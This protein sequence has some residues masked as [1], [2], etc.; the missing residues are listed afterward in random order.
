VKK[1]NQGSGLRKTATPHLKPPQM[2]VSNRT[3]VNIGM[4]LLVFSFGELWRFSSRDSVNYWLEKGFNFPIEGWWYWKIL[5]ENLG[6]VI[7]SIVLVRLSKM[8]K[9]LELV[10]IMH[11]IYRIF[12][13]GSFLYNFNRN[14]G[15]YM[16]AYASS[17]I[18]TAIVY[19]YMHLRQRRAKHH[20]KSDV[21]II[22]KPHNLLV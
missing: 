3:Y 17:G 11:L 12:N 8:R 7:V 4:M 9:W 16:L 21:E 14:E 20:K 18:V 5:S 10:C 15:G 13:L 6:W 19:W 2:S 22:G 1:V